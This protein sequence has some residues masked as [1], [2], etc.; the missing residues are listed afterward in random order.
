MQ[1]IY[2]GNNDL[3]ITSNGDTTQGEILCNGKLRAT[4]TNA[5]TLKELKAMILNLVAPEGVPDCP[6]AQNNSG[7]DL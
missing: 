4:Y 1:R 7:I 6:Q 3:Y 2:L 5:P